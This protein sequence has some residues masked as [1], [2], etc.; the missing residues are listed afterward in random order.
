MTQTTPASPETRKLSNKKL[1][2]LVAGLAFLSTCLVCGCIA[3]LGVGYFF[4]W[5]SSNTPAETRIASISE[6]ATIP[7]ALTEL[8]AVTPT[9]IAPSPTPTSLVIETPTSVVE[10][11]GTE[12][13]L[14]TPPDHIEQTPLD[15]DHWNDLRALMTEAYP[16]RD[17]F[18]SAARLGSAYVGERTVQRESFQVGARQVF[19]TEE[20]R[21]DA[22]L[23]AITDHAYFWAETT[24]GFDP[25]SVAAAAER[26][27]QDFYPVVH[28]VFGKEWRPGVDNDDHFSILHLEGYDGDGELGFFNSG[29]EYP[30]AVVIDSN[31]QEMV[32]LNMANLTLG[33]DLYQGTL[34]HEIHHLIQ[35]HND[36]NESIWI[37]EGLAQLIEH[38]AGLDTVDTATDYLH[39]PDTSL[40]SWNFEDEEL[41]YAHYGASYLFN[42]YLWEQLGIAAISALSSEPADGL[43]G[44][45]AILSSFM[46]ERTLEELVGNWA[47]ANYLDDLDAGREYG[48][49]N[50]RLHRPV[51]EEEISSTEYESIK[52]INQYG[53]HYT[54]LDLSGPTK[55]TFVGDTVSELMTASSSTSDRFWYAPAPDELDAYLSAD[56][57]LVGLKSASLN[58]SAWYDLEEGFDFAY[59]AISTDEGITWEILEPEHSIGGEYGPAFSGRSQD[60][61]DSDGGWVRESIDLSHYADRRATIR[62][63][64]LTDSAVTSGGFAVDNIS[65]PETSHDLVVG[66]DIWSAGGFV[67]TGRILPQPWAVILIEE[68]DIPQVTHLT[69][70]ELNQGQWTFELGQEGG[71]LV[72]AALNPILDTPASYWLA[73]EQ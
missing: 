27:E 32:Y 54:R 34:I 46:P 39:N 73:A 47:V 15:D 8:T 19:R 2:W 37:N 21:I 26:F 1:F 57:D 69:L 58:F 67:Q 43:A 48:Y 17:Y 55:I 28:Q 70:N 11:S 42:V 31:Q 25:E 41:L 12:N 63:E 65:I 30:W 49:A 51:H 60:E 35:W 44:V 13:D 4:I 5:P 56:I 23:L 61:V 6:I 36:A 18:E 10:E 20:G 72:V 52:R 3:I 16:P 62:F 53:V 33:D 66:A 29:D 9:F 59:V 24:L 64:L 40:N 68:G 50:L 45:Q 7:P 71:V 22:E 38:Y 14:I